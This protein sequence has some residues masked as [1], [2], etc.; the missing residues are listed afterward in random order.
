M[1]NSMGNVDQKPEVH[2]CGDEMHL[3]GSLLM[4][5]ALWKNARAMSACCDTREMES[6]LRREKWCG[7]QGGQG[8]N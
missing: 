5:H 1:K 2:A 6:T 7:G 3:N 8:H 4:L